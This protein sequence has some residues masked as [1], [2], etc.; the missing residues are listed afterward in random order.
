[1][2]WRRGASAV[3]GDSF[4]G[5]VP[6]SGTAETR[7]LWATTGPTARGADSALYSEPQTQAPEPES[8]QISE[9]IRSCSAFGAFWGS[10]RP[11]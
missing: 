10:P 4:P 6:R 9:A 2:R 3:P 1:M 11:P 7:T 8:A 5:P